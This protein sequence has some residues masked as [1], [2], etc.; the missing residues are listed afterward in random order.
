MLIAAIIFCLLM[1]YVFV[2][3]EGREA[4]RKQLREEYE[5]KYSEL[6]YEVEE[7]MSELRKQYDESFRRHA[8]MGK[9]SLCEVDENGF[10]K[11][12]V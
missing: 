8:L 5:K 10:L 3:K 1:S 7:E 4:T 2:Y 11:E 6:A 9:R 12:K